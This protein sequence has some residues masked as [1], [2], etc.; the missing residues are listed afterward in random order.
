M[1]DIHTHIIP[2]VDDG[3]DSI[4]KSLE[5]VKNA[6][7]NGI[8]DIICTPHFRKPYVQDYATIKASFDNFVSAVK[9][10][11]IAVN[12]YLGRE[13]FCEDEIIDVIKDGNFC[14]ENDKYIL[15]EFSEQNCDDICEIVYELALKGYIPIVAHL[16]RYLGVTIEDAFEIKNSG[17]LIQ[18]NADSIVGKCKKQFT[19]FVKQL[20][21]YG[22]VD[23]VASDIHSNRENLLAKA[24][25]HVSKKY[26]K[27]CANAIFIE[28]GKKIISKN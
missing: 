27:Q 18:V 20:F 24:Y 26:G 5:I 7:D 11:N 2:S 4:N 9:E 15:I 16:E 10:N 17:G 12:L 3:S 19:K 22:L 25:K 8:T 23:F 13:V 14:I 28:N 1:I 6:I 21:K